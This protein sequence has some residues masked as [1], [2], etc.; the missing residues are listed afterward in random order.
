MA[1]A[2]GKGQVYKAKVLPR[3]EKFYHLV[4]FP[5]PSG[6]LHIGHW[7]N[8]VGADVAARK[9]MRDGYNVMSPIGFD[10]F[11]LPAENAAIKRG[12]HPKAWTY[13]N[14][15]TMR[16]QLRTTGAMFDWSRE[17]VTCDPEYYRWTQWMFLKM[18]E[19]GLA[20]RKKAAANWCPKD[21]T[22]LANEQVVEGC[23]ERCGTEVVQKEI[24]QWLLKITDYA[25]KLL[26]DLEKLDWP[27]KTKT[28]Q[29]NWIGR[30]EGAVIDFR[31]QDSP[32]EADPP[33]AEGFK[34]QVFTT[35]AD[36]LFGATY[37][38]L[39]PEH[40]LVAS[41]LERKAKS[42]KRK[43]IENIEEVREYIEKAK[44]KT[45]LDRLSEDKDKTGVELKGVKAV[46][47]AN[48]EEIP[49]WI[50]DYVLSYGTGAIW[51]SRRTMKT[52][53][54]PEIW[55]PKKLSHPLRD[56]RKRSVK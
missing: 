24:D 32:P 38:V 50:S 49:I 39:A 53:S 37:L 6:D 27:E 42:E 34:I 2:V 44:R 43:A 36:T 19:R 55:A 28:M 9:K 25:E 56:T 35:R 21:Q 3:Q 20:Y 33:L 26:N 1:K 47:P 30:S 45:E 7:Y 13:S 48:G 17:V 40:P 5:Y 41:L 8:F 22:V 11:G 29:K 15:D 51:P 52:L 14:M 18:Y 23:C 12:I 16:E 54:L 4:M 46:N 31:I 10:A